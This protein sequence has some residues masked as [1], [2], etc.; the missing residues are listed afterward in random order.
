MAIG[1]TRTVE[2]K[3]RAAVDCGVPLI[4]NLQLAQG[5]VQALC[6]KS[7]EDLEIKSWQE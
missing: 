2:S 4:T 6:R 5:L 7:L 1:D 3:A